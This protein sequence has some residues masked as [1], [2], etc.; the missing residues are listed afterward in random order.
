MPLILDVD[1][2]L[3]D[4]EIEMEM[5]K[6]AGIDFARSQG[7][8]TREVIEAINSY[9]ADAALT[10]YAI[11][12]REVFE[13]CPSLKVVSRTGVGYDEI[14]VEAATEFGVAICNV[15][16][17]GDECVSDH[18]IAL[19][20]AALRKIPEM[21]AKMRE[22]R[23][24]HHSALPLG[25]CR[26]RTFGVIGLGAIGKATARKAYG[27]GFRVICYSPHLEVGEITVEGYECVEF[28]ELLQRSDVISL[29][30]PLT[31]QTRHLIDRSALD[32]MKDDATL[33]NTARGAVI[34]TVALAEVLGS[35]KLWAAALDVFE[36]EQ[37]FD[38]SHPIMSAPRTILTPHAAYHS[39]ESIIELRQ[40][41][42]QACIDVVLGVR[43]R[44]C[45]N[46]EVFD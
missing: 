41:A 4:N 10:S 24:G 7:R 43:P 5:A 21:D 19:T 1:T 26:G 32:K 34:D 13:K 30:T 45:L 46:V 9:K 22:G 33:V 18:A 6:S 44:N 42:M 23:W 11:F 12:T 31:K 25:Q 20:L 17:Y 3:E 35:G 2:D 15:P 37:P 39:T 36:E 14:D 40:R 16:G 27:L 29:H 8:S 28:D 38:F